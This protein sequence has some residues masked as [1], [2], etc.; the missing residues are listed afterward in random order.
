VWTSRRRRPPHAAARFA[1]GVR[2]AASGATLTQ[3]IELAAGIRLESAADDAGRAFRGFAEAPEMLSERPLSPTE[4]AAAIEVR[5]ADALGA[6]WTALSAQERR[7]AI[8]ATRDYLILAAMRSLIKDLGTARQASLIDYDL[9]ARTGELAKA[10]RIL[11]SLSPATPDQVSSPFVIRVTPG[12][13]TALGILRQYR[14]LRVVQAA[15]AADVQND[16]ALSGID[17][18][19]YATSNLALARTVDRSS[20]RQVLALVDPMIRKSLDASVMALPLV[21]LRIASLEKKQAVAVVD[22]DIQ[23]RED[24]FARFYQQ[25]QGWIAPIWTPWDALKHLYRALKAVATSA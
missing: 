9:L 21:A 24:E 6:A 13:E 2:A 17:T 20:G 23:A 7:L 10:L 12:D 1:E 5:L 18:I 25:N 15:T 19:V 8:E 11:E 4:I 22:G 3:F 14:G 16:P